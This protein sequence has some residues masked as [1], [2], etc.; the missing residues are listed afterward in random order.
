MRQRTRLSSPATGSCFPVSG[1]Y[2]ATKGLMERSCAAFHHCQVR[3]GAA[4]SRELAPALPAPQVRV[5]PFVEGALKF[6]V[7]L[8]GKLALPDLLL[9]F[10]MAF[11]SS[12]TEAEI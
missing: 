11:T 6:R 12:G 5:L 7:G 1:G 10:S 3:R 2:M 8:A 4:L 9:V